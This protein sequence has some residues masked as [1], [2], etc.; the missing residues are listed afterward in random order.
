MNA[1]Q[2]FLRV[3]TQWTVVGVG[4]AGMVTVGL[5]YAGVKIGLDCA[6][7]EITPEL[8]DDLLVIETGAIEALNESLK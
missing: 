4:M 6:G 8:W 5:N 7:I 2:A 1:V 3:R